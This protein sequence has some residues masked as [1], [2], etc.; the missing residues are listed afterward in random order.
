MRTSY[1]RSGNRTVEK[2][3]N[4]VQKPERVV[5][6][7]V[8]QDTSV[9]SDQKA[10]SEM[11]ATGYANAKDAMDARGYV[12]KVNTTSSTG[13]GRQ[14]K[15]SNKGNNG[16]KSHTGLIVGILMSFLVVVF[17]TFRLLSINGV[18]DEPTEPTE[19]YIPQL[20]YIISDVNALYVDETKSSIALGYTVTDL[21]GLYSRLSDAALN[22]E[23]TSEVVEELNTINDY[24]TDIALLETY[25]S[26]DYDLAPDD[27]LT[28]VLKVK[29][30]SDD[31]KVEGLKNAIYERADSLLAMRSEYL[32]IKSELLGVSDLSAFDNAP[33]AEA[34]KAITHS[35]NIEEL[36]L[37]LAKVTADSSVAKAEVALS[38]AR[39]WEAKVKAKEELEAAKVV[40]EKTTKAWMIYSGELV[41]DTTEPVVEGTVG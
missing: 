7:K 8:A 27:V 9:N 30:S 14:T 20:E 24:L 25:E 17:V 1:V 23:D 41:P 5:E 16:N 22:G 18:F 35:K 19:P 28:N 33:Y 3:V 15:G 11:I 10:I 38:E 37:L 31:Y 21:E 40:Q 13:S 39:Y 36:T 6:Q 26:Q 4:T 12:S 32:R 34:I 2:V 29:I